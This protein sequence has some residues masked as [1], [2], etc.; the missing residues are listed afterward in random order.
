MSAHPSLFCV[1]ASSLP[2]PRNSRPLFFLK[3]RPILLPP[4]LQ[5]RADASRLSS[6]PGLSGPTG[7]AALTSLPEITS[8]AARKASGK[9]VYSKF[10]AIGLFSLLDGAGGGADKDK[11]AAVAGAAG[12]DMVRGRG[13]RAEG[14][15]AEGRM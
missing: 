3:C 9:L 15:E 5:Y 11:L 4:S 13:E 12:L 7:L 8:I 1:C 6:L 14:A 10:L 2:V